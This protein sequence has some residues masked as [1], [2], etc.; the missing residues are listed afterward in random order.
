MGIMDNDR[1]IMQSLKIAIILFGALLMLLCG[2][3]AWS[4]DV[5]NALATA[6]V[7]TAITVVA[8]QPLDFG[9]VFQG[10]PKTIGNNMDDSTAIFTIT[11]QGGAGINIQFALPEYL[12]LPD[13]SDRMQIVFRSTDAAVDTSNT[14]TPSTMVAG[15]GWINQNPYLLPSAAVIGSPGSST[16]IYLGGRVVP[17]SNQEAGVYSGN[18]VISVSYNGL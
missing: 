12:S 2:G 8:T 5:V 6:T 10:M 7:Q 15:D 1:K 17:S 3:N 16:K 13:G 18:I 11:G 14:A 9:N 4:Q